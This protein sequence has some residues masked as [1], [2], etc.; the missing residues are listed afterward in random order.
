[1]MN[2]RR[3]LSASDRTPSASAGPSPAGRKRQ[4]RSLALPVLFKT[5][6]LSLAVMSTLSWGAGGC[7]VVGGIGFGGCGPTKWQE[8]TESLSINAAGVNELQIRSHNGEI[9]YAGDQDSPEIKVTAVKKGGG[10]SEEQ[11]AEALEAIEVFVEPADDGVQKLGWRWKGDKRLNWSAQVNFE[12]A[13]PAGVALDIETHNGRVNVSGADASAH[14][15]THNGRIGAEVGGD[16][17]YA[18]TH[19]GAI[20]ATFAGKSATLLTHNGGIDAALAAVGSVGGKIETH[21]GSVEVEF[22]PQAGSKVLCQTHNG[23]IKSELPGAGK[24]ASRRLETVVGE[25]GDPLTV[26]THNGAIR[27]RPIDG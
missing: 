1:M 25:G 17:L 4:G 23:R 2:T 16:T 18:R 6:A 27:L 7:V 5:K 12:I 9:V 13:G 19:N 10:R 3:L 14:I 21:N 26:S 15:V 8:S 20:S 11:A 24:P 22:G